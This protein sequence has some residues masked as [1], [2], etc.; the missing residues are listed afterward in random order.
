MKNLNCPILLTASINPD[1]FDFVGRKGV[2]NREMDY[3]NAIKFY[4]I[5]G[6]QVVFIDNSNYNSEKILNEFKYNSNFEY[7]TFQSSLSFLGKGHGEKEIIDFGLVNS[8]FLKEAE[9]FVKITGRIIVKNINFLIKDIEYDEKSLVANLSR[10]L[11]WADT[12]IMFISK[13]FF[14][15]Y[16]L[17]TA[18]K[19]L[20]EKNGVFFEKIY[21]KSIHS[22]LAD[23]GSLKFWNQYPLYRGIN[24]QN[25]NVF[26]L[27]ILRRF[28]YDFFLFLKKWVNKQTI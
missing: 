25:G 13:F 9:F 4:V 21:A 18:N 24:G 1:N 19:Y 14:N 12:R 5:K 27:N 2:E 10:N 23:K 3:Y 15:N 28:K 6:Y 7:L 26:N 16:F 20:D 22:F 17:P 8:I 11:S